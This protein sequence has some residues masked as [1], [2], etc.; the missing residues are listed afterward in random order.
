MPDVKNLSQL[1][2]MSALPPVIGKQIVLAQPL[3]AQ[4]QQQPMISLTPNIASSNGQLSLQ[5]QQFAVELAKITG[6]NMEFSLICLKEHGWDPS[7]ALEGFK[8]AKV[9]FKND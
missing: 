9:R 7:R 2:E 8:A 4:Q 5:Q 1:S 3:S 6:L